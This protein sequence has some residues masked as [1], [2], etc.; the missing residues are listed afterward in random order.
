MEHMLETSTLQ[1]NK[2]IDSLSP[3]DKT[4]SLIGS[5]PS[6]DNVRSELRKLDLERFARII[7]DIGNIKPSQ[8][9]QWCESL[10]D[11]LQ[12]PLE[13]PIILTDNRHFNTIKKAAYNK[14]WTTGIIANNIDTSYRNENELNF[15]LFVGTQSHYSRASYDIEDDKIVRLGEIR[16][17]HQKAEVALRNIDLA[18]IDLN[19]IRYSDNIG[20]E[21]SGSAGLTIEE[22][23][24]IAKYIGASINLKGVIIGGYDQNKDVN[25]ITA[26]NISLIV[27][28][29]TEG[30]NIRTQEELATGVNSFNTYTIVPDELDCE[31]TFR[32]NIK[33]GRWWIELE[34]EADEP[35]A[36]IPCSKEDYDSACNNQISDKLMKLFTKV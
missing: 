4:V 33:S 36:L 12:Y 9:D 2:S 11:I 26:K 25:R 32:E 31:I 8:F 15:D 10:D 7:Q 22:M 5:A 18:Y 35:N 6:L 17:N 19:A 23:C 29:L 14:H 24:Q 27:W 13:L 3:N 30:F 34:M 28:Y 1:L 20:Y 21:D 16:A